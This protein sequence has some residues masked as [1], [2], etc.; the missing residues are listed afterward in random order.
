MEN[1]RFWKRL[2]SFVAEGEIVIDRPRGSRHPHFPE[3]E[4]P[5]DYGYIAGTNSAD[6]KEI[7]VWVGTLAERSMSGLVVTLDETKRDAEI[8]VLLGC[9]ADD[10]ERILSFHNSGPMSAVFVGFEEARD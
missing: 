1:I 6:G 2:R 9:T 5:L 7:D 8:K 4:Y 10:V 3:M